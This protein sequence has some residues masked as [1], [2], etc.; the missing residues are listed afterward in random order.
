MFETVNFY[1]GWL[2]EICE[3]KA[4]DKLFRKDR[5]QRE[6]II[7]RIMSVLGMISVFRS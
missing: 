6:K 3:T 4:T 2:T 7:R 5:L 1:L